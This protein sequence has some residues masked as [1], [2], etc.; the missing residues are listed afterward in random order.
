MADADEP[1]VVTENGLKPDKSNVDDV[2]V[3]RQR[4]AS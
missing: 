4:P 1:R 2:E 3:C